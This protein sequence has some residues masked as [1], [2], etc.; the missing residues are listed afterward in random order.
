MTQPTTS[1]SPAETEDQI[2]DYVHE[3]R[4][5][6]VDAVIPI[7]SPVTNDPKMLGIALQTLDGMSRDALGKK[8]IKVEEQTNA[9]QE[10]ATGL[11]ATMLRRMGDIKPFQS[12][13]PQPRSAPVTLPSDLPP[14]VLV[15]GETATIAAQ[16]D[17]ESFTKDR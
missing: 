6:I 17:Y 14:P 11:I 15:E 5:R 1:A 12:A 9:S 8:R 7:A 3:Q 4:K 13:T 10:A 2:L 16:S